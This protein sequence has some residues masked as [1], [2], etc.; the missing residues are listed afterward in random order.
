MGKDEYFRS[1]RENADSFICSLLPGITGHT[2][3]QYSPGTVHFQPWM[4]RSTTVLRHRAM[5]VASSSRWATAT[6]ST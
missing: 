6:C 5:Q 1:F 3:I 4:A 2:Q